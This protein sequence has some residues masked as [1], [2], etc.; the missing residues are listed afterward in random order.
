EMCAHWRCAISRAGGARIESAGE[1]DLYQKSRLPFVNVDV[2]PVTVRQRCKGQ[3]A[4]RVMAQ[5]RI[6]SSGVGGEL[7]R[8]EQSGHH[9]ADFVDVRRAELESSIGHGRLPRPF[10]PIAKSRP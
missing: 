3:R 5:P 4:E 7:K 1:R 6:V 8:A 9:L 2:D 10:E